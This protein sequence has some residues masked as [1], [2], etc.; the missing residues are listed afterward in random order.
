MDLRSR[1]VPYPK[2]NHGNT[3]CVCLVFW[4]PH[5]RQQ[6]AQAR[7]CLSVHATFTEYGDAGK[8]WRFLEAGLWGLLPEA[9]YSQG[10]YLTFTP[11]T[12][13]PDPQP[14]ASGQG[15]YVAGET[16]RPC[17]GADPSYTWVGPRVGNIMGDEAVRRSSRLRANVELMRRQV[18]ALR[19]ALAIARVLNRT[20]VLPHF[21]C[22]C[23]RSEDVH[24]MPTCVHHGAP[25]SLAFPFKC[26]QH[27]VADTHKLQVP[28]HYS[29]RAMRVL[30]RCMHMRDCAG[31]SAHPTHF[32]LPTPCPRLAHALPTSCLRLAHALPTP[33]PRPAHAYGLFLRPHL[34][35]RPTPVNICSVLSTVAA[36]FIVGPMCDEV[37]PV[38]TYYAIKPLR[39][40]ATVTQLRH[41]PLFYVV[42]G[43]HLR[44]RSHHPAT[45]PRPTANPIP[46]PHLATPRHHYYVSPRHLVDS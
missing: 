28:M 34:H 5:W 26:S 23:D 2:R 24:V 31:H 38:L 11:P 3:Y 10:R 27:F 40:D 13:P 41:L 39:S 18:H 44:I 43:G 35:L 30:T 25:P 21:D 32:A 45:P 15:V 16:P 20:L 37:P 7:R 36:R 1:A 29:T 8:R 14:C 46:S 17:G 42:V 19:D 22:L 4:I 33:C 9:Y 12:A 6:A